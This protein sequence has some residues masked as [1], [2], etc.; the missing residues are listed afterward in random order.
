MFG[1]TDLG[2][3]VVSS[4]ATRYIYLSVKGSSLKGSCLTE[5][6]DRG[7][8]RLDSCT[9]AGLPQNRKGSS[10]KPCFVS[11]SPSRSK[12]LSSGM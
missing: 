10:A 2:E 6:P 11:Q 1:A 8:D 7:T 3:F 12:L 4:M 9:L 5:V